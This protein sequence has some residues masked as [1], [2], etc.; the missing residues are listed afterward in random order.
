MPPRRASQ[1]AQTGS[2]STSLASNI[3]EVTSK[4]Q[5]GV[6]QWTENVQ[7]DI[8]S[9]L[10]AL[11]DQ[12]DTTLLGPLI[13]CNALIRMI[14]SDLTLE[15]LVDVFSGLIDGSD[16]EVKEDKVM[17]LG[18]ALADVVEVLQESKEDTSDLRVE[19]DAM[20][21][22]EHEKPPS[23]EDKGVEVLRSL[24]VGLTAFAPQ[25]LVHPGLRALVT[26]PHISQTCC[27]LPTCSFVYPS[28]RIP[29]DRSSSNEP[30][31]SAT[32]PSSSSNQSTTSCA[33]HPRGS[34]LW[35][36][37]S[38]ALTPS[39]RVQR[40]NRMLAGSGEQSKYGARSWG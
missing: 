20:D 31:S 40:M 24:I 35:S 11:L 4:I 21:Q 23:M 8:Q 18:E 9:A 27:S 19:D 25:I 14:K 36:S 3:D 22:D 32:P 10:Q 17:Q 28:I 33:S 6:S 34:Q 2:A 7:A 16:D 1:K 38:R 15:Q 37:S 13:L 12:V 26:S 39:R 29:V 30:T 5:Q